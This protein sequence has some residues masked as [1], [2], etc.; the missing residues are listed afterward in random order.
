MKLVTLKWGIAIAGKSQGRDALLVSKEHGNPRLMHYNHAIRYVPRS[1]FR[2]HRF[3]DLILCQVQWL[4]SVA[5]MACQRSVR[6]LIPI[7]LVRTLSRPGS[8][9]QTLRPL[10]IHY[11][12]DCGGG[13]GGMHNSHTSWLWSFASCFS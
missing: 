5:T 10:I 11:H 9:A 13:V 2:K 8:L 7:L 3:T 4:A 12:N 1:S 6:L